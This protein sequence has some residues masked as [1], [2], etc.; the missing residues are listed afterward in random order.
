MSDDRPM[1]SD[2]ERDAMDD[3]ELYCAKCEQPVSLIREDYKFENGVDLCHDCLHHEYPKMVQR[4][5]AAE[6][7][8]K[9]LTAA[10][11]ELAD[12]VANKN[13]GRYAPEIRESWT[14]KMVD[15]R[16]NAEY[17]ARRYLELAGEKK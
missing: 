9:Q 11:T 12:Y 2:D 15:W 4:A 14:L 3:D 10:A 13:P 7:G 17:L 16:N 5:T 8:L 6:A 1:T